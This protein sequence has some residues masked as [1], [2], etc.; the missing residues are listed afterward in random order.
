MNSLISKPKAVIA[1]S[2]G[3][4]SATT[5]ATAISFGFEPYALH[6]T[7]GQR[8]KNRELKAF[9]EICDFYGI[10]SR[11]II[12]IDYLT[13]IGGSALTDNKI[14]I[15][16]AN[17]NREGVPNT[18]VPFRNGNILSIAASWAEVVGANAIFIGAVETDSSGY[19]DCRETF[20]SAMENAINLGTKPTTDI[21]IFTP[22][23]K[24]S[25]KEI[26][27]KGAELGVPFHLTWSCY[28]NEDLAC[29]ECDSCALRL[30]GFQQAG[31]E[32]PI[33]YKK[34]TRYN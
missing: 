7:Y 32:D 34:I 33:P 19:P 17:L 3:M 15:Q 4:D 28:K 5:L 26:V 24:L 14:E 6:I 16:T 8:T 13:K 20:F 22:L 21:K 18:Y 23:I 11:L 31:L 1:L 9:N 29:G 2:G 10:G 25:K 30:R 27:L 12:P